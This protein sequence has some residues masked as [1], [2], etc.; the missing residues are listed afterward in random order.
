M[1]LAA[2]HNPV[3]TE[4][5]PACQVHFGPSSTA[6]SCRL[7]RFLCIHRMQ[8]CDCSAK[9]RPIRRNSSSLAQWLVNLLL[10]AKQQHM[11]RGLLGR[12]Y[13]CQSES[14]AFL[15]SSLQAGT[16]DVICCHLHPPEPNSDLSPACWML[17]AEISLYIHTAWD[18]KRKA[19]WS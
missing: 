16:C 1:P 2:C 13:T 14:H 11:G 7:Y 9:E 15:P 8:I 5:S 4:D 12:R 19:Q 17:S 18:L 3:G 6:V 10:W